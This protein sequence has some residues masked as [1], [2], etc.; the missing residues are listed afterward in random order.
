MGKPGANALFRKHVMLP[1]E[2]GSWIFLLSPLLI[3]LVV[4]GSFTFAS[5]LLIVAALAA[6]LLRQPVTIIVEVTQL[7]GSMLNLEHEPAQMQ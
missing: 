4:G 1:A 7:R 2:H 3:G 5:A 6:F